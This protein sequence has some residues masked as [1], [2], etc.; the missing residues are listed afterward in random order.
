MILSFIVKT[1]AFI[2]TPR[3]ST[4]SVGVP[5]YSEFPLAILSAIFS[6]NGSGGCFHSSVSVL[7]SSHT[8]VSGLRLR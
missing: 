4:S 5:C 8:R 6:S 1:F 3:K 7:S 2:S